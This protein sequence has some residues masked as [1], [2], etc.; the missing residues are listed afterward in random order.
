MAQIVE[1]DVLSSQLGASHLPRS[2]DVVRTQLRAVFAGE[3]GGGR[4]AAHVPQVLDEDFERLRRQ[5]D[6]S[7]TG[8]LG[9]CL[10]GTIPNLLDVLAFHSQRAGVE[11]DVAAL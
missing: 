6:R 3:D 9:R 5:V 11:V 10:G 1:V 8:H 4:E 2:L 7:S